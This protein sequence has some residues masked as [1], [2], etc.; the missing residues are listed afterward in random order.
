[1]PWEMRMEPAELESGEGFNG[2]RE[3]KL[4][5][6]EQVERESGEREREGPRLKFFCLTEKWGRAGGY[7]MGPGVGGN[8]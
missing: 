5:R 2:E 1:M 3:W 6:E 7:D 4:R 8:T